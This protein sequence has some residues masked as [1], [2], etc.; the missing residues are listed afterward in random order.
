MSEDAQQRMGP[1]LEPY[2]NGV[3]LACKTMERTAKG[4]RRELEDSLK[5][6]RTDR[7]DIYQVH[8]LSNLDEA[9]QV[10]GPGGAIE[11]FIEAKQVGKVRYIGF[12][13]HD[14]DAALHMVACSWFAKCIDW[15]VDYYYTALCLYGG[16]DP[17]YPMSA[18]E[19]YYPPADDNETNRATFPPRTF[20]AVP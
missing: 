10:L 13:A 18:P 20:R 1:A 2:P 3:T 19:V 14:Q 11:A 8:A 17:P 4:A 9:K 15:F 7:F 5:K 16:V 12:S 6:L